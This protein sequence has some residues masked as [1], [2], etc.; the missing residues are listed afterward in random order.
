MLNRRSFLKSIGL[1]AT[2]PVALLAVKPKSI[3]DTI[4][5]MVLKRDDMFSVKTLEQIKEN[6]KN[7]QPPQIKTLYGKKYYVFTMDAP[8][9][10]KMKCDRLILNGVNMIC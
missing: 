6:M 2:A 10:Q 3:P 5:V 4:E 9:D 1:A 8:K 7:Y